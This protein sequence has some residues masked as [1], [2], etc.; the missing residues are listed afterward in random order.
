MFLSTPTIQ[1]LALSCLLPLALTLCLPAALLPPHMHAPSK[2]CIHVPSARSCFL[3]RMHAHSPIH[4][5]MYAPLHM[6]VL[7]F[8]FF[9]AVHAPTAHYALP[10]CMCSLLHT[11]RVQE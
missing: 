3:P 9:P 6:P 7:P 11:V 10:I 2:L 4:A 5:C 8:F 1:L